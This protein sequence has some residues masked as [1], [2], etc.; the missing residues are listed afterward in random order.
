MAS[1][2]VVLSAS[3][4][5]G[6]VDRAFATFDDFEANNIEPNQ[7][8]YSFLL[9]A[10]ARSLTRQKDHEQRLKDG[11]GRLDAASA[12]LTLMEE[13]GIGMCQHCI[14]NYALL[15]FNVD[16]LEEATQFLVD[17]M[18]RGEAV[19]NRTLFIMSKHNAEAGNFEAAR[20]L[21][22]KTTEHYANLDR[23]IETAME[24]QK[25]CQDSTGEQ[26]SL[27]A[28]EETGSDE[29]DNVDD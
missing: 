19:S 3:G 18:E 27:G 10:L 29:T 13:K 17:A 7:D 24:Q 25:E 6:D 4:E 26:G 12:I 9:E 16:K 20:L 28:S 22:S 21:A 5:L 1:L 8:S 23:K 14:D 15:L 2:N 11:P